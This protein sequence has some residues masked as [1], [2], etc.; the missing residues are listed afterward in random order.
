MPD[1]V[2]F[3]PNPLDPFDFPRVPEELLRPPFKWEIPVWPDLHWGPAQIKVLVVSDGSA[4]STDPAYGFSLGI[5]LQDAFDSAHPEHPGYARFTFTKAHRTTADGVTAGFANFTFAPGSLDS[6]D[7]VWLFGFVSSAPYLS[8]TEIATLH[9]F[10]D[11]GG[12]VLAMG[13][14][15]ALGLG[16]CGGVQR[17]RAMRKWWFESPPPPA[18][19]LKAPD[20]TDLT[21]NDTQQPPLPGSQSDALPQPIY[22]NYRYTHAFWRP[23][24]RAQKYPH[25]VLCG[26]RGTIKVMPDHAHEGDCIVPSPNFANEFT[27]GVQAEVIARG[28]NVVGREKGGY[29]VSDPREFGLIG[30]WDGHRPEANQGRIVV[31]S[32]WHHWFNVNLVGLRSAGGNNYKD[33][34]AYFR[35]VA[36]W[37]APKRQQAAMRRAGQRI[38]MLTETLVEVTPGLTEFKPERFYSLGVL[39]RDALGRIAPQCQSAAWFVELVVPFM[40]SAAIKAALNE[41]FD[42]VHTLVEAATLD[43]LST[44]IFGGMINAVAIQI[45]KRGLDKLDSW[46]QALDQASEEGA[47]QGLEAAVKQL[48]AGQR[49][50]KTLVS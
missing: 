10:M 26:P 3:T 45:N 50:L 29:V 27:G 40:P 4:Y 34:L 49:K 6:F 28:R 32:T 37:L 24:W 31:D 22:P 2:F 18:G 14:H 1:P 36:I 13:D 15:E 5:A 43:A 41:R 7:E 12:G 48:A 33:I 38:L 47:K 20:I 17:V 8:S 25:P 21:R 30:T 46:D 16:L 44:T 23:W 11:A 39:A 42:S 35:N 9:A 19:M